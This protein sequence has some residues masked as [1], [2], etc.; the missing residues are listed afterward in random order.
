MEGWPYSIDCA[1]RVIDD[2]FIF[3]VPLCFLVVM[4]PDYAI[5][6]EEYKQILTAEESIKKQEVLQ[7]SNDLESFVRK[8]ENNNLSQV[9]RKENGANELMSYGCMLMNGIRMVVE[10]IFEKSSNGVNIQMTGPNETLIAYF[11][12]ALNMIV[13][14]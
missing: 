12:H 11:N 14:L 5:T 7:N 1:L 6:I 9:F 4:V 3:K 2:V 13:N 8:L 10:I